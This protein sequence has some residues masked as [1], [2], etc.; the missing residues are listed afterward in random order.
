VAGGLE[1]VEVL[2][3]D[4]LVVERDDGA[5]LGDLEEGVEVAV[6][7]DLLVGDHL[8]GADAFCLGQEAEREAHVE[9]GCRHHPGEL[10]ASD[11]R[12]GG[13]S[14]RHGFTL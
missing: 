14:V 13:R 8:R 2:G 11:D 10:A 12:E 4:V 1:G 9:G 3:R 5:A 6:V 7:T